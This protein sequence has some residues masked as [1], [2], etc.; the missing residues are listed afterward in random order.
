MNKID[1]QFDLNGKTTNAHTYPMARLLDVIREDAELTGTKEGCGEGECGACSIFMDGKL[2]NSCLVPALQAN[3]KK[4]ETVESLA[5][6]STLSKIQQSFLEYGGAQCGI[7]TPGMLMAQQ[8]YF[9]KMHI[10]QTQTS[11][12]L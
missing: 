3:N 12:K 4:I 6:E 7:C 5:S 9:K 1:I 10:Q 8:S 11:E 2:V